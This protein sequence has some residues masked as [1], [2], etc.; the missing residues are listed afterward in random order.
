MRV[1]FCIVPLL[2]SAAS[3]AAAAEE[4]NSARLLPSVTLTAWSAAPTLPALP[5]GSA[6]APATLTLRLRNPLRGSL[7]DD[8]KRQGR[9]P[10]IPLY[11]SFATLQGLD[12]RSTT[13]ALEAGH[14]EANPIMRPLA[15]HPVAMALA[16]TAGTCVTVWAAEKLSK[17]SRRTAVAFM[18]GANAALAT[19]VWHNYRVERR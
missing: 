2:I 19:I 9:K 6:I 15:D 16:K 18:A 12:I 13:R 1:R 14:Q 17:R 3:T 10:L 5:A 4:P 8:A 7:R 11:L